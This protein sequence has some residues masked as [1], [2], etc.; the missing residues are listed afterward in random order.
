MSRERLRVT[1]IPVGDI[2]H[3][4]RRSVDALGPG[5]IAPVSLHR[6]RAWAR[7]PCAEPDDPALLVA[8]QGERCAGYLGLLAGKLRN[9]GATAKLL[10]FSTFYV[11]PELRASGAGATL[12]LRALGL[13][14]DLAVTF[15]SP[16]AAQLYRS[17]GFR[18]VGP[19]HYLEAD[20][21][22]LDPLSLPLRLLRRRARSRRPDRAAALH[23]AACRVARPWVRGVHGA[24]AAAGPR[25]PQR[26]RVTSVDPA[27]EAEQD[28]R[29][30][31]RFLRDA[32]VL[33]WMLSEPW[34]VTDPARATPAY[35][36]DDYRPC[37]ALVA[38]ELRNRRD[39]PLGFALWRL[40]EKDGERRLALFDWHLH[41]PAQ[42]GALVAAALAEGRAGGASRIWLPAACAPAV[43]SSP[44]LR[45]AFRAAQRTCF[46]HPSGAGSPLA[47]ALPDL[48]LAMADGDAAFA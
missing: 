37:F 12:L 23:A 40:D 11:A 47:R 16:E 2:E 31:V 9:R 36:F 44:A 48:E 15:V 1:C 26:R 24:L 45:A 38:A 43:T 22:R 39:E 7:N 30:P 33:G 34:I 20:L 28:R 10:W 8:Y 3:F 4:A 29:A 14:R 41:D 42:S 21:T 13:K 18:E 32:A 5:D 46:C 17:L 25:P 19:L 6:A 35:H 27:F